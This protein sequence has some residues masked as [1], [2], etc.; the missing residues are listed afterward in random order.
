[1]NSSM[2]KILV[3]DPSKAPPEV[4]IPG[5]K[6]LD[7]TVS[8]F[9]NSLIGG[10][11][12]N[13][14]PY[15]TTAQV[16]NSGESED[17]HHSRKK[18]IRPFEPELFVS[19]ITGEPI[20]NYGTWANDIKAAQNGGKPKVVEPEEDEDKN[21]PIMAKLKGQIKLRGAKGIIGLSRVFKIMDDDGSKTLCFPEFKK[22]MKE[23]GMVLSDSEL[24]VLFKRFGIALLLV[25]MI[26]CSN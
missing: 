26:E 24:I 17:R 9:N 21:D 4:H 16:M 25:L 15:A 19:P 23:M 8:N 18:I 6:L 11:A 20:A 2:G 3:S 22:A 7:P 12:T 13:G 1:M 10:Q 14:D 5:K